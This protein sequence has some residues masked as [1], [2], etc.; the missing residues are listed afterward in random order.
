MNVVFVVSYQTQTHKL[1][2]VKWLQVDD[3]ISRLLH[4]TILQNSRVSILPPLPS[5]I[6]KMTWTID[7]TRQN[8]ND[9]A[10]YLFHPYIQYRWHERTKLPNEKCSDEKHFCFVIVINVFFL[11]NATRCKQKEKNE[12][13]GTRLKKRLLSCVFFWSCCCLRTDFN[14][15]CIWAARVKR[16]KCIHSNWCW[17]S[18]LLLQSLLFILITLIRDRPPSNMHECS[19]FV[20]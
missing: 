19:G 6:K 7:V 11:Y 8:K 9:G 16:T 3:G 4:N 17:R 5:P 15:V 18:R 12:Q 13:E 20:H 1:V 14:L 10:S 2:I